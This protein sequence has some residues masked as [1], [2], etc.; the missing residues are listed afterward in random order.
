MTPANW[1]R[2]KQIASA[3]LDVDDAE[4][5]AFLDSACAEDP[6]LRTAVMQLIAFDDARPL[7]S[8]VA[9]NAHELVRSLDDEDACGRTVGTYR[10]VR[11]VGRGGTG[12]V[13]LAE[14]ADGQYQQRVAIKILRSD[15]RSARLLRH[16][17]RERQLLANLTHPCI[18]RLLDAGLSDWGPPYFVM[19]YLAGQPLLAHCDAA[20]LSTRA[21]LDLFRQVCETVDFAHQRLV[22][23]CDLKPDNL[24]VTDDGT[25]QVLDFGVARL[26]AEQAEGAAGSAAAATYATA[27][28]A[29]P[30]QLRG[31]ALTTATDVYSLGVVLREL[32]TGRSSAGAGR[33]DRDVATIID[34]ATAPAL[35]DRYRTAGELAE[36]LRRH[37]EHL[38]INA[39]RATLLYQAERFAQRHTLATL[40]V[41]MTLIVAVVAFGLVVRFAR[42]AV[43][44]RDEAVVATARAEATVGFLQDLLVSV[45]P[46]ANPQPDLTVRALLDQAAADIDGLAAE[47]LVQATVRDTLGATYLRLGHADVAEA[48]LRAALATRHEALGSQHDEV[49]GTCNNLA[50]ALAQLGRF[51]EARELAGRAV[52]I[53]RGNTA[54]PARL[55]TALASL[56]GIEIQCGN[57]DAAL[58]LMREALGLFETHLPDDALRLGRGF[59]NLAVGLARAGRLAEAQEAAEASLAIYVRHAKAPTPRTAEARDTLAAILRMR[60]DHAAAETNYRQALATR[61]RLLDP[62]HPELA[63][64]ALGLGGLL[65]ERGAADEAEPLLREAVAIYRNCPGTHPELVVALNDLA[66]C[67]GRQGDLVGAERLL[68]EALATARRLYGAE[69][70]G[71]AIFEQNLGRIALETNRIDAA[72]EWYRRA[73]TGYEQAEG[74]QP[75]LADALAGLSLVASRRADLQTA[76]MWLRDALATRERTLPAGHPFVA[77]T[78][79]DLAELLLRQERHA[80]AAPLLQRAHALHA[81]DAAANAH[82]R[83]RTERALLCCLDALAERGPDR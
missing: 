82:E 62:Q 23:H 32:L 11:L 66:M 76:E 80:E 50:A 69:H 34:R 72:E 5:S 53:H 4:R 13:Y 22:I 12:T 27:R 24:L 1:A 71:N 8:P 54:A 35:T 7:R 55:A 78:L 58:P 33:L 74:Y 16:F 83:A 3:T 28:Y 43:A 77:Q 79:T 25:P 44:S 18:P 36:D 42:A 63:R 64:T 56:G 59:N 46:D 61:E 19:D 38:P 68:S 6:Q 67:V 20:G 14:R 41:A 65:H 26:C 75:G 37:A 60:G 39:R 2:L 51:G 9:A 40:A 49:A 73:L 29:S 81:G 47:P 17:E 30:E 21:R 48:H 52:A 57:L 45:S 10:L 31:D 15:I 70:P